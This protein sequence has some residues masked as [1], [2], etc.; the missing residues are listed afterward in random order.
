MFSYLGV[1]KNKTCITVSNKITKVKAK[2]IDLADS[3]AIFNLPKLS[4]ISYT[5]KQKQN[6]KELFALSK[7][8]NSKLCIMLSPISLIQ[9]KKIASRLISNNTI[10]LPVLDAQT[11]ADY[12]VN[13]INASDKQKSEIFKQN[14]LFGIANFIT[15]LLSRFKITKYSLISGLKVECVGK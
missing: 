1:K 6:V 15:A 13:Q 5:I 8:N 9:K 4:N 14:L 2:T 12:V 10:V 7:K 3:N 11:I